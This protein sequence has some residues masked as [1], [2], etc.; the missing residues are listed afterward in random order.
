MIC[1][2]LRLIYLS[3]SLIHSCFT[4][5]IIWLNLEET[6]DHISIYFHN[7]THIIKITIVCCCENCHKFTSCKKFVAVFLNLMSSTNQIEII[8]LIKVSHNNFSKSIRNSS[9]VF[10]PIYYILFRISWVTP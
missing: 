5:Q 6:C 9:I 2:S 8:F 7:Y 4:Y 1:I 3:T 10:T